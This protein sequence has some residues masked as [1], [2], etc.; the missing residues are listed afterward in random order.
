[1]WDDLVELLH[2]ILMTGMELVPETSIFNELT[3]LIAQ[4]DFIN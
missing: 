4:E 2:Q 3:W 1:M